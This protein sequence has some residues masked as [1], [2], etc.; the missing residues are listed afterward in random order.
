M[1]KI[2]NLTMVSTKGEAFAYEFEIGV[3]YF[4]GVNSSG[5][6]E[7]YSFIDYM[8]GSSQRIDNKV[9]FKGSLDYAILEFK[10]DKISYQIKRTM[11]RDVNYFKYSDEDFGEPINL[12]EYKDKLNS[13]FANDIA[14][15]KD[16]RDFT[17]EDLSFR[18]F[19]LFN[20]LGEKGLGI[21]NDFFDKGKDIK[22]AVKL[23]AI[24]NYIFN[25]NLEKIFIL[26]K[27]LEALQ[28][29]VKKLE[30]SINKFEFLKNHI[31]LNLKKLNIST[32]YT[33]KNKTD[34]LHEISSIKSLEDTPKSSKKSKTIS[35]LES[36][37]NSLSDQIKI[38]ENTI[39]D[40]KKFE[41][42][43][44]NRKALLESLSKLIEER[45]EFSYLIEPLISITG[46]LD[47]SISFNKYII[48]NNTVKELKK[49][50]EAVKEEIKAN[51][52]RFSCFDISEKARAIALVEEYMD[53]DIV[54][55]TDELQAKRKRIR[56]LNI[57]IKQLQNSD[58]DDKVNSLSDYITKL[59]KS[60]EDVSDIVKNDSNL[61]G[62]YIQYYKK[63]NMLQPKIHSLLSKSEK[64]RENY[65]IGS[66]ARHTLIQLCGYLGFLN[67]L[68]KE[69]KYPLVPIFVID[70][71]SKPFDSD[72]RKAIGTILQEA[73]RDLSK[74]DFQ[75]FMFDDESFEDLSIVPDHHDDLV[76][77][78]KTGFNPFYHEDINE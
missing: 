34:I 77:K 71:I 50:R 31:N 24:L 3:N 46:D 15:L 62:F 56:E 4:K 37:H 64:D 21:L 70:H 23:P 69:N 17:E 28:S 65:Y 25:N 6:T 63:G 32:L 58:N 57:E 20:F 35:E 53:V 9:W 30:D 74:C 5:K 2:K 27:E 48:N 26:K 13:I 40:S 73:Y 52:V 38:Y 44:I 60:A 39:E 66:M 59:Y 61:D 12:S 33:G 14:F 8:L 22:Y 36:I 16:I 47:K 7:F 18:T 67:L 75:I 76:T 49:H 45:S 68:I 41:N 42:E 10:C 78:S 43:N 72:N 51:E 19:T 54:F 11:D 1:F 55:N 29:E